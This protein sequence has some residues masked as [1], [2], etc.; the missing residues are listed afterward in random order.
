M[1]SSNVFQ[2]KHCTIIRVSGTDRDGFIVNISIQALYDYKVSVLTIA[3]TIS[4]VFQFKHCTIISPIRH[5]ITIIFRQISIQALYDYKCRVESIDVCLPIFQFK[6]CTIIRIITQL[7]IIN[8]IAFQF[9]HCTIIRDIGV[10][11]DGASA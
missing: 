1:F 11:K 10:N 5:P 6:H 2:F 7:T 8:S 4:T 9:K 3:A